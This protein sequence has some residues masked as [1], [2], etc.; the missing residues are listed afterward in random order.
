MPL[1][2]TIAGNPFALMSKVIS[3]EI[4]YLAEF[5]DFYSHD[6]THLPYGI[7]YKHGSIMML[8]NDATI[9]LATNVRL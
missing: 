3:I 4:T 1:V 9:S 7:I 6:I 5:T 2:H 8:C